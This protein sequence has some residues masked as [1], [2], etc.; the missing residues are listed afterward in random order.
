MQ[1]AGRRRSAATS[2]KP[3]LQHATTRK[4]QRHRTIKLKAA[5]RRPAALTA[6]EAEAQTILDACEHLRDRLL[7][8]TSLDTGC[9]PKAGPG[10][11]GPRSPPADRL[12]AGPA[13]SAPSDPRSRRSAAS[14]PATPRPGT[15]F[16]T[17]GGRRQ[18]DRFRARRPD[19]RVSP[20]GGYL[21]RYR[22]VRG[23]SADRTT[24]DQR[25]ARDAPLVG[26][27]GSA[28]YRRLRAAL[29]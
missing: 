1:P 11:T 12:A 10:R 13:P 22:P 29:A 17:T 20:G 16:G 2:Y 19:R 3:F 25:L 24:A 9:G 8:A 21:T 18:H 7:F 27:P 5:R 23:Y 4:P 28:G 14:R 15:A 26:G 6:A